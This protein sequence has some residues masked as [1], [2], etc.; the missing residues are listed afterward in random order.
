MRLAPLA[1]AAA[2]LAAPAAA[3]TASNGLPVQ[4]TGPDSFVVGWNGRSGPAQFWCAAGDFTVRA[5]GLPSNT[6]VYRTS[7]APR[8]PGEGIAF[9]LDP[10]R[11]VDSGLTRFG[12]RD[13]GLSA[14]A[15]R[16]LCEPLILID[17]FGR[18]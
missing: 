17:R 3:F 15:A 12:A 2:V 1:L 13:A 10:S 18:R 4:A 8:A 7:P 6:R 5:L 14:A 9:S 11:A 16:G